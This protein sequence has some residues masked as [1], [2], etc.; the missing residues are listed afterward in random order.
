MPLNALFEL[1]FASA[2]P[3]GLTLRHRITRRPMMQKVRRR[4]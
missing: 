2:S 3:I 1:A 4:T